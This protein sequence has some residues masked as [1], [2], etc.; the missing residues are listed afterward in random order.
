VRSASTRK[1]AKITYRDLVR[2]QFE[3]APLEVTHARVVATAAQQEAGRDCAYPS[4]Q[5]A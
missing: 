1:A 4:E 2:F 5:L 3:H